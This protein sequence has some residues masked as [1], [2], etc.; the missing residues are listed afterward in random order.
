MA[1][2]ALCEDSVFQPVHANASGPYD[3]I[4]SIQD[5]RLVIA[6][7]D[8]QGNALPT[9]VLSARPY[10]RLIRDYFMMIESCETLRR[11]GAPCQ[12]ESVDMA[13][14]GLH[15]EGA[16]LLIERLSGKITLDHPTARRLFTLICA[17][18]GRDF[19]V[20]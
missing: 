20:F 1:L 15:N 7:T 9:L 19:P 14:R 8:G 4:L 10:S 6:M 12:L 16:D 5:G 13:R 3:L 17:L 18:H 11:T 2:K